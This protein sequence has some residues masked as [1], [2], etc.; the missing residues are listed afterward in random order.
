MIKYFIKNSMKA[1]EIHADFQNTLGDSP[2]SYS[3]IAKWT[4][5]FQFDWE[6]LDVPLNGWSKSA[7]TPEFIAKVHKM[8]IEDPRPTTRKGMQKKAM[9][10]KEKIHL[11]S[12]QCRPA[13]KC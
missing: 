2:P 6:S 7:T 1:K 10:G 11:S 13:H 8:V 4:S 12:G 5:G 9:F 3:T